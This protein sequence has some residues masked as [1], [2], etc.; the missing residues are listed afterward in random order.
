M[1]G[2]FSLA[3]VC[4]VDGS[5]LTWAY[6]CLGKLGHSAS[7]RCHSLIDDEGRITSVG[8]GEDTLLDGVILREAAP[9]PFFLSNEMTGSAMQMTVMARN[10][11]R[12]NAFFMFFVSE[13]MFLNYCL[14]YLAT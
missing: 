6:R 10:A 1:S 2:Y 7:T 11:I 9:I 12:A 5:R 8:E 3:A 14:D 4:D 13:I